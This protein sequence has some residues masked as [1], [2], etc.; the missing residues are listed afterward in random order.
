MDTG[1][2]QAD[3]RMLA[4]VDRGKRVDPDAQPSGRRQLLARPERGADEPAGVVHA[5][6]AG[7]DVRVVCAKQRIPELVA[8]GQRGH[9]Q[10]RLR[11]LVG[12]AEV[13]PALAIVAAAG[14]IRRGVG[15]AGQ[16]QRAAVDRGDVAARARE[17]HRCAGATTS[18]SSR[19]GC[20][21]SARRDWS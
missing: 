14:R 1:A 8:R 10:R 18:Q 5:G 15:D 4:A 6:A 13:A 11:G 2:E 7:G 20:R 3:E 16:R 17:D 9:L 21:C 19:F 12:D